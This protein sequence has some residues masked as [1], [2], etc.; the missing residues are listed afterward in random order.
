MKSEAK[1]HAVYLPQGN[2]GNYVPRAVCVDLEPGV[3]NTI[4]ASAY[5]AV[6]D[7]GVLLPAY[8]SLDTELELSFPS[9]SG[10]TTLSGARMEPETA[11]PRGT[12]LR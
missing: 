3:V 12:T 10:R 2:Q 7:R 1:I 5:G 8:E 9:C 11:G 4:K 6:R